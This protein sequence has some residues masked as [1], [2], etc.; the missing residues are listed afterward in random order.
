MAGAPGATMDLEVTLRMDGTHILGLNNKQDTGLQ[1]MMESQHQ[2]S[3]LKSACLSLLLGET[4]YP[5]V[6]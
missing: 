2:I 1:I 3:L 6:F 4:S 5:C